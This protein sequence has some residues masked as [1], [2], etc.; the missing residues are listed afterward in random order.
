VKIAKIISPNLIICICIILGG[1]GG[2]IFGLYPIIGT[3]LIIFGVVGSLLSVSSSVS[4]NHE[5]DFLFEAQAK[6][7]AQSGIGNLYTEAVRTEF[8]KTGNSRNSIKL[9]V[10]ALEVEPNNIDALVLL[11]SFC[12]FQLSLQQWL[13]NISRRDL[14]LNIQSIRKL[15]EKGLK[16]DSDNHSFLDILGILLDIE[17][18]HEEARKYFI[19]SGKLRNDP[20]WHLLLVMSYLASNEN[21]KALHEIEVAKN[22]G[23][24]GW[25]FNFY[26]GRVMNSLGRFNQALEYLIRAYNQKGNR[27]ELLKE[28][29]QSNYFEGRFFSSSKY[30]IFLCI[31]VLKLGYWVGFSYI[32]HAFVDFIIGFLC[33]LS[34]IFWEI[35]KFIPFI[36]DLHIKYLSPDEP[37]FSLGNALI[38]RGN[39]EA[40]EIKFR[41]A[42]R[43]IPQKAETYANIALCLSL[44]RNK[45][46]A[47]I[48]IDKAIDLKPDNE[49]FIHSKKQIQLGTIK[50][51]IDQ[52][53][54]VRRKIK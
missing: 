5:I 42:S 37:E 7:L 28:L 18:Y 52:Y 22:N 47:L 12:V 29:S 31:E 45:D 40:A 2:I 30:E 26:Y 27:P 10:K 20:Y 24:E 43:I 16:V 19:K 13:G 38:N 14:I 23:A 9:L 34:K 32:M 54:K 1:A 48:E 35:T 50:R 8:I 3:T 44:L 21:L 41:L 11:S 25:L 49:L 36:K 33:S 15:A 4:R 51:I 46:G 17:G 6:L 39:Y 53:G